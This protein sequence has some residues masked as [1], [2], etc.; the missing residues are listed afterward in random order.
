M[1]KYKNDM[2]TK[3][4]IDD[5]LHQMAKLEAT[6]GSDSTTDERKTVRSSQKD[7]M[8]VIKGIDRAFYETINID[9]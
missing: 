9:K 2:K 8:K 4:L 1:S 6:L 3:Q 7:C 5:Q